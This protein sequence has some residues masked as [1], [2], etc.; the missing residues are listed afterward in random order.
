VSRKALGLFLIVGVI[1][2]TPYFFIEIALEHFDTT[3]LVFARVFL[4][5]LI[6]MPIVIS[7]GMMKA[8]LKAWPAVVAFASF[9]MVGPWF[10][11]P[12]AQKDISSS[13]A[14]LLIT[15]VPFIAAFAVGLL[16]DRSAWHPLTVLGLLIG[17]AG[18]ISLVG[19]DAFSGVTPLAPIFMMLASAVGYAVAPIIANRM[20]HEVPT[21]GVIAVSLTIVSA[22][23]APF[24]AFSLPRD[25]SEG[26][27]WQAWAALVVLGAICSALAFVIFF[28]LIREIG[29]ARASLITYVN[30]AVAAVLGVVFLAEPI[31][32]G[33]LVGFPLVVLGSYLASR[34]RQAIRRKGKRI[35]MGDEIPETL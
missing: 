23:Y 31:T 6:L 29:P 20:P 25:I 26:P 35:P 22:V 14:S 19:I 7:R 27:P 24:A 4:G 18:V 21:L 5:A 15:T 33:I 1:W 8:T 28:A 10:L 11:I 12:E 2:G 16:G 13:L 30:L 3:S 9:E 34:Q 17:L 32:T